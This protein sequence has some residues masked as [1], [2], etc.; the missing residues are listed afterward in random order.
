MTA[1]VEILTIT[2]TRNR[3]GLPLATFNDYRRKGLVPEPS[4]LER[5]PFWWADDIER[6]VPAIARRRLRMHR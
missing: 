2:Q 5:T 1:R 3:L 4:Y 6:A